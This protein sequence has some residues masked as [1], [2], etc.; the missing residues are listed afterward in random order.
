VATDM[1][2]RL[3]G[4][5][6]KL[7]DAQTVTDIDASISKLRGLAKA[8]TEKDNDA[9]FEKAIALVRRGER[10][11]GQLLLAGAL[12]SFGNNK[13]HHWRNVAGLSAIE[14]EK[15]ITTAITEAR[16]RRRRQATPSVP[17]ASMWSSSW[18]Q[19]RD[20]TLTR[21]RF[22]IG[23]EQDPLAIERELAREIDLTRAVTRLAA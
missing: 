1:N 16:E 17:E 12:A 14:F 19:S 8:A 4:L 5:R 10:L 21:F 7:E 20:G 13:K 22:A 3:E 23:S 6:R 18:Y 2:V 15:S 9:V 11:G